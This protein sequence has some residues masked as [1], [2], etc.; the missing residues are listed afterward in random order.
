MD[1][2]E[3]NKKIIKDNNITIEEKI[4]LLEADIEEH[5]NLIDICQEI[6]DR[7]KYDE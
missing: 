6:V 4:A 2:Y 7:D 5:S 3:E 1:Y